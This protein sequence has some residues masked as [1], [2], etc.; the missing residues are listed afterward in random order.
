MMTM[1]CAKDLTP[2]IDCVLVHFFCSRKVIAFLGMKYG[3][4]QKRCTQ[5][6]FLLVVQRK[7]ISCK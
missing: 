5:Y 6:I 1:Y 2:W 4:Y 7:G 3:Y